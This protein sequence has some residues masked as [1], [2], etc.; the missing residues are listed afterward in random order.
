MKI[1][2]RRSF[3]ASGISFAVAGICPKVSAQSFPSKPIRIVVPYA[4]G[5][6][7]DFVARLIGQKL[8][9]TSGFTVV[10][11]NKPGA[12]G[13]I[14]TDYAAKAP[15]DGY[16]LLLADAAHA[17]NPAVYPKIPYDPIK[18][19]VPLTLVG[20]SPQLLV[21]NP[22]FPANSLKELLAMPRDQTQKLGVG[23][24]G[25]GSGPNLLYEMLKLKT[26][27]TLVHVPYK[28]GAAALTDVIA[29]QIP[30]AINSIPACMPHIQ[31]RKLKALAIATRARDPRLPGVQ[32]FAESA[33]GIVV[34]SWYG[35]LAPAHAPPDV[36]EKL[37]TAI[38]RVLDLPEVKSKFADAFI[39]PM[40][41]GPQAL[42]A[43]LDAETR[44]WK[45]VVAQTGFKMD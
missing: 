7:S 13:L 41:R 22:Q 39:D 23:T 32:T 29:G 27:L 31:A 2:S 20:S 26:G 19:F 30:L 10:V 4:P 15:A 1:L 42:S 40:P 5:G 12:S 44:Q 3:V 14:G 38:T 28:G 17:T 8:L 18:D 36:I 9:E 25:L 24:N 16:V 33:S 45:S 11:D 21:A 34:S 43:F 37:T 35:F 6:G